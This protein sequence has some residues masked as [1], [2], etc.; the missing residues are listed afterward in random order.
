MIY[1]LEKKLITSIFEY[2]TLDI[3][4]I[5][6]V[7]IRTQKIKTIDAKIRRLLEFI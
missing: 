4:R 5:E 6:T 1:F 7:G 3:T 2:Y